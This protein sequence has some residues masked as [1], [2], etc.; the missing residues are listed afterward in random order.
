MK[1]RVDEFPMKKVTKSTIDNF[2][3]KCKQE[4]FSM[5]IFNGKIFSGKNNI[6]QFKWKCVFALILHE[7]GTGYNFT[8]IMPVYTGRT[9][10][11]TLKENP[12]SP[13]INLRL[14]LPLSF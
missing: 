9:F 1:K 10:S 2:K 8:R 7:I 11:Y 13:Q 3:R 14:L 6:N 12:F 4:Y 5:L